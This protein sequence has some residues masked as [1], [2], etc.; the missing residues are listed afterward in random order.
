[1]QTTTALHHKQLFLELPS[2]AAQNLGYRDDDRTDDCSDDIMHS[3][4]F[5]NV[6]QIR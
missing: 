5:R 6:W 3:D 2:A 4:G 1:M